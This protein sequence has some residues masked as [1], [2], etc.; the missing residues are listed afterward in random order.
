MRHIKARHTGDSVHVY[1]ITFGHIKF[2]MERNATDPIAISLLT[3]CEKLRS[4]KLLV[5][6]ELE[7][8]HSLSEQVDTEQLNVAQ[9]C[10]IGRQRQVILSRLVNSHPAVRPENCCKLNAILDSAHFLDAYHRIGSQYYNT[11]VSVLNLILNSPESVAEILHA[12]DQSKDGTVEHNEDE[13]FWPELVSCVFSMV[14][15]CC[16]F[17]ADEQRMLQ[18]L[19][20]LASIQL[21]TCDNPRLLLRKGNASFCRLY[22]LFSE[23]L[24]A[25]K[26]FLTAALHDPIMFLLS[27]NEIF[28]DIDPSK[29]AIRFPLEERRRR[30]GD[31]ENSFSYLQKLT[32]HRRV[33]EFKLKAIT[34]RFIQGITHAMTCFPS[35]LG[36]LIRHINAVLTEGKKVKADEAVLICTDLIFTHLICPAITNPETLGVI[37][38]TPITY[39][40]RFNL[41]QVG[42]ILQTLALAPYEQP[43]SHLAYFYSH[44]DQENVSRVVRTVLEKSEESLDSL[45]SSAVTESSFSDQSVRRYFIGMLSELQCLHGVLQS[46]A[47]DHL[48]NVEVRKELRALIR[49]LPANFEGITT[50]RDKNDMDLKN[51]FVNDSFD[52]HNLSPSNRT[53]KLRSLADKVQ[54]AAN[55]G[56]FRNGRNNSQSECIGSNRC[57][58]GAK[59]EVLMFPLGDSLE[60][61][62]LTPEEK[63]MGINKQ[64][65]SLRKHKISDGSAE[66]RTRFVDTESIVIEGLSDRTTEVGSDEEEEAASLS[67]SIEANDDGEDISTLPDNFS[68]MLPVS[69]NVSGRESPSVSGPTS[70][71]GNDNSQLA[72]VDEHSQNCDA[73]VKDHVIETQRHAPNL[74]VLVRRE[75][76]EELEDQFGKFGLS[77]REGHQ[78]YRDDAHSLISDSWSTDVLPSDTEGFMSE[79]RQDGG[80]SNNTVQ[81]TSIPFL[82]TVAEVGPSRQV[83]A[84]NHQNPQIGK[85]LIPINSAGGLS[86]LVSSAENPSDTW[87]VAATAS[88]SEMDPTRND[89]LLMIDEP[90]LME[91]TS[92][93]S[94]NESACMVSGESSASLSLYASAAAQARAKSSRSGSAE[95]N[96][97]S[98]NLNPSHSRGSRRDL[99]STNSTSAIT[100]NATSS[101]TGRLRRQS[102]GSSFYSK[103]DVDSEFSKDLNDDAILSFS[104]DYVPSFRNSIGEIVT[105]SSPAASVLANAGSFCNDDCEGNSNGIVHRENS[106]SPSKTSVKS[107]IPEAGA[108]GA[109]DES[110]TIKIWSNSNEKDVEGKKGEFTEGELRIKSLNNGAAPKEPVRNLDEQATPQNKGKSPSI[111][112]KKNIFHGLQKVGETL[113][114]RKDIAVSTVRQSLSQ[115]S[116]INEL[117]RSSSKKGQKNFGV[118]EEDATPHR[119]IESRSLNSLNVS[120][121]KHSQM[122]DAILDKYKGKSTPGGC[123]ADSVKVSSETSKHDVEEY[124]DPYYDPANLTTCRAFVDVKRKLRVV[125]SSISSVPGL[126]NFSIRAEDSLSG[127]NPP[128]TSKNHGNVEKLESEY[129]IEFLNVLLA[130]SINGQN[131]ALS[132]QIREVLRCLSIFDRKG[133]RKLL[134][135]LKDEHRSRTAY[136]LYLQQSRLTL[137]QLRAYLQKLTNRLQREKLLIGECLTEVLVR[138][139]L[140]KYENLIVQF[141]ADFQSLKAQD[142]RMD[143]VEKTLAFLYG[144]M[145][146]D[147]IWELASPER[148]AYAK[149]SLERSLMAHIYNYAL[150]PNGEVD[151]C[152]DGYVVIANFA[153]SLN[154]VAY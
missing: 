45:F 48:S 98:D 137:L 151:Q 21:T 22:K 127:S 76:T 143:S 18:V 12:V 102:S 15:G 29:S 100:S 35:S 41:M 2:L 52:S 14:F 89:D 19:S 43:P 135:T 150:Y 140:E 112:I 33:I 56:R 144:E 54:T 75:N 123:D 142:E 34:S 145:S 51:A 154:F 91:R 67:S 37:S 25:A 79:I 115:S 72:N 109:H 60:P 1:S 153:S 111:G 113:K 46:S 131:K 146:N 116:S 62:G 139:Y 8:L 10:W 50:G 87:S 81:I 83:I 38:D 95:N 85:R 63:F 148:I 24:F 4:E 26:V 124:A 88:D 122:A 84:G 90:D 132:A 27:Q 152:R 23:E 55:K 117:S 9:L 134:R 70:V 6:S 93:T 80:L 30:F 149:K 42:Q 3:L 103:S 114:M 121:R 106:S 141:M 59:V 96:A 16:V 13:M 129:I 130:E 125:L 82:P 73:R 44:F 118:H 110:T 64:A 39:I 71:S 108:E 107:E 147:P 47:L 68:D 94:G 61:L 32:A 78:K 126:S 53:T 5:A 136:L 97:S 57:L 74:P 120:P 20:R 77:H 28:L 99:T 58:N 49:R 101:S 36:W 138:F 69:A 40:A 7:T 66:K 92:T 104:G 11:V 105:P 17:P 65:G 86:A 31:D 119:L 133:I 128:S